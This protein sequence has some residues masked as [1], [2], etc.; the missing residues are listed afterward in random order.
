MK[1]V[2]RLIIL[3][4]VVLLGSLYFFTFKL[5][6]S[7]VLKNENLIP[8][9]K[10]GFIHASTLENKEKLVGETS[11]FKLY[12]DETTSYFW[13]EDKTT[14]NIIRS[15]PNI[16]DPRDTLLV[17]DELQFISVQWF[18][19]MYNPTTLKFSWKTHGDKG[20]KLSFESNNIAV[21]TNEGQVIKPFDDTEV[22]IKMT[23]EAD[24]HEASVI[25]DVLV[26][27]NGLITTT[28][29]EK[30][31]APFI[32]RGLLTTEAKEK[33]KSTLEFS[34]YSESGSISSMNNYKLSIYHPETIIE[35]EGQRTYEI[36]YLE[37]K[38]GFQV[39]YTISD[40]EIDY[41]YFPKYMTQELYDSL[42]NT[43]S[44]RF[45]KQIMGF[46]HSKNL[47][48]LNNYET[49]TFLARRELYD[50]YYNV[51]EGYSRE[52]AIEENASHGY[53]EM[54]DIVKFEI[55]VEVSLT[56]T[57]FKTALI[58]ESIKEPD[59]MKLATIALYPLLGTAISIHEDETPTSGY[60]VVPDGSGAVINFNNDK[61]DQ[62]AYRKRI[63]GPD[64]SNQPIKMPEEQE[65]VTLPLYGMIKEDYGIAS[66][67][68]QGESMTTLIADVSERIDSYNKIYPVLN[69]REN[70]IYTLGTGWN[71]YSV[72]LWSKGM[73][74][75]DLVVEHTILRGEDNSYMGMA[76]AYRN[77]LLEKKGL[78]KQD[79][80]NNPNLTLEILGA[81]DVKE[82]VLGIPRS[83]I[84]SLTTFKQAEMIANGF[85]DN[86]Y[87]L[88]MLYNGA[89]NGGLRNSIET[90]AKFEGILGGKKGY[91]RL[92]NN[93]QEKDTDVYLQINITQAK[94]FRRLF[95]EY[96]Y[97]AQRLEGKLTR[98]FNYHIP[99]MLPYEEANFPH[100]KDDYVLSARYYESV[101]KKLN[102]KLPND[103]ISFSSLGSRLTGS[104]RNSDTVYMDDAMRYSENIFE[105]LDHNVMLRSPFGFTLPYV[106][107]A[108]DV[109]MDTTLYQ[110]I[111]YAI[112]LMQLVYASYIP[113]SS[114]SLNLE[115]QRS[116]E[117]HF[118]KLLETG[119][120][121]K[122]TLTYANPKELLNTEYTQYLSTYYLH[123]I[124]VIKDQMNEL[125][126]L[127]LYGG[128][129]IK[130]ERLAQN[131][132]KVTYSHG[133]ELTLN[134]NKTSVTIDGVT[135]SGLSYVK[136]G[137]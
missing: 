90:T 3:L 58:K 50:V 55:G 16:R 98:D 111:D 125:K 77:Y 95:D 137:L 133:L 2:R 109:S 136:G 68:T 40:N 9:S 7:K 70:Y 101:F 127:N 54:K 1:H 37:D 42:P 89:L 88:N 86:G 78:V 30:N 76:K 119:S 121:P 91:K 100:S 18:M 33:Q 8:F 46:D 105:K 87:E 21:I 12:I 35:P 11:H 71:T 52:R 110:I 106:S 129:L 115:V 14:G 17:N 69:L 53:L 65:K 45:V 104:Y 48:F 130:H 82:Y 80:P 123:W 20:S 128:H 116:D 10:E 34:Y 83:R 132:F 114:R 56:D 61:Q 108:V 67:V 39:H 59:D 13:V 44:T 49:L 4:I 24:T 126:A 66:I 93:L 75:T 15:N 47:Y 94:S 73:A 131:V 107:Y 63:Y 38:V 113:Y 74:N 51:L 22:E 62:R 117:Y 32:S 103:Y 134:Y 28:I 81:Y 36:K 97:A 25:F 6:A 57:G 135:I 92:F 41:L 79:I 64:I 96:S 26:R 19:T 23:L 122:Y 60:M 5:K 72:S 124:E 99:T 85:L 112:P 84:K 31:E 43:R 29:K 102:K 120:Q 118:L 27:S